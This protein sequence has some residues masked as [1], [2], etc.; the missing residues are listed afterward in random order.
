MSALDHALV[1]PEL[2][3]SDYGL[4]GDTRTAALVSSGGSVG[5]SAA[6]RFRIAPV[7]G[8][9]VIARRYRPE[10]ATV[11]TTWATAGGRLTLADGMIAEP[12]RRLLPST[13]LVRHVTAHDGPVEVR[14]EFDPR[15]G[16][17][18]RRPRARRE[19]YG[20]VCDWGSL[21]VSLATS[22]AV[23]VPV[24]ET[25]DVT[26]APGRPLTVALGVAYQEPLVHMEPA[27]AYAAL[28]DDERRWRRWCAE[29]DAEVAHRDAVVRSL[30]TLRLLTYSPSGA[31][32]AAPTTSLPE[33]IGG[34]R[35]W[36]YR[37]AWPRD[38]S[39]GVAAMVGVGKVDEARRFLAWLLHASRLDRPRL[40]ALL[41]VDGRR[42]PRERQLGDW[43]GYQHSRPVRV[44]NGAADQHQLD[45]YGWVLDAAWN[46]TAAGHQ[47]YSETWRAMRAFADYVCRRWGIPTRGSGRCARSPSSTSTPSSW[48][49]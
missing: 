25:V 19:R 22:S 14:V 38:A 9:T 26:V 35:N 15:L 32:V 2:P 30:L 49:G 47:L 21:A 3:I 13:L 45:V 8:A 27:A 7:T 5:A 23:A 20:L 43:P 4:L 29:V 11:E 17:G 18:H 36:D 37:Y 42:A 34:E 1:E 24:G 39:I 31:P 44:G 12:G 40:P 48:P 28:V 10:T 46:L 33:A 41:T 6:G 16:P